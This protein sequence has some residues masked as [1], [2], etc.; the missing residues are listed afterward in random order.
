[1]ILMCLLILLVRQCN[2]RRLKMRFLHSFLF[3]HVINHV[4]NH[5][6]RTF[7]DVTVFG[8]RTL[9]SLSTDL[10]SFITVNFS[11]ALVTPG[12]TFREQFISFTDK[13]ANFF[14]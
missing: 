4:G 5:S 10:R 14:A 3:L 11:A 12:K 13:K 1:M 6:L 8:G 2:H 7:I 9:K